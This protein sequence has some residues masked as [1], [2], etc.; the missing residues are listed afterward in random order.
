MVEISGSEHDTDNS[1]LATN[2]VNAILKPSLKN[3]EFSESYL[4][5]S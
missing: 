4:S 2:F 3:R 1:S 5:S